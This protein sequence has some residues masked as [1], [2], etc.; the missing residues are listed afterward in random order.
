MGGDT[1]EGESSAEG[2]PQNADDWNS[3]LTEWRVRLRRASRDLLGSQVRGRADSSDVTQEG[4]LQIWQQV[5]DSP[6]AAGDQAE[7]WFRRVGAGHASKIRRHHLAKKRTALAEEPRYA[8]PID[9]NTNPSMQ[10]ERQETL[11]V[12]LQ[13][14]RDLD[15]CLQTVVLMRVFEDQTFAK[16]AQQLEISESTAR[17]KFA[18]AT[19]ELCR[20]LEAHGLDPSG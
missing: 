10:A 5:K 11:V 18:L 3:L 16:I 7:A 14:L 20:V 12:L 1:A 17:A 2:E 9:G 6:Q 15:D 4:M 19:S 13:A 8:D